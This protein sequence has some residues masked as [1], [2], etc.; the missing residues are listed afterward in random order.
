MS[1]YATYCQ[2]QSIDCARRARLA[3]SLE[4]AT[5][6]RC[7]G[8]RWLRLAAQAHWTGG[9]LGQASGE[10]GTSSLRFSDNAKRHRPRPMRAR[11]LYR[12]LTPL[13]RTIREIR[14]GLRAV[15]DV[16]GMVLS[17]RIRLGS[18]EPPSAER[19]PRAATLPR[20]RAM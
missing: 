1:S 11:K 10:V 3:R 19:A 18:G 7:L 15:P 2:D 9:A 6:W 20:R 4:V 5:Y 16:L 8:S 14:R 13:R 12:D 17:R